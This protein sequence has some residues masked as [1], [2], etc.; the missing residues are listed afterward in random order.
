MAGSMSRAGGVIAITAREGVSLLAEL[1][2]EVE[3]SAYG[4]VTG[5]W[6]GCR[7]YDAAGLVHTVRTVVPTRALGPVA[8]LLARTVYSPRLTAVLEYAPPCRYATHELREAL[9][10][11]VEADDDILTQ[12]YDAS[13]LVARLHAAGDF[14]SLRAVIELAGEPSP[15]DGTEL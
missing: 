3:S 6:L 10:R 1:P 12:W 13:D 14:Q 9:I 4:I 5:G 11:A 15:D 7:L 2:H 8:R